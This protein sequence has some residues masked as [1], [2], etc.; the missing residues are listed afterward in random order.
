MKKI[1]YLNIENIG[2]FPLR[3]SIKPAPIKQ[4][5]ISY[6]TEIKTENV[7]KKDHKSK[8]TSSRKD[9]LQIEK[10]DDK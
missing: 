7:I 8:D 6:M 10:S 9:K 2:Q 4:P 1:L 3:Y 5:S